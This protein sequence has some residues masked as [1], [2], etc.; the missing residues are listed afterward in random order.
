[1][2]GLK[3]RAGPAPMPRSRK[4]GIERARKLHHDSDRPTMPTADGKAA[5]RRRTEGAGTTV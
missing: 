3:T 5:R 4:T 2:K 1:M